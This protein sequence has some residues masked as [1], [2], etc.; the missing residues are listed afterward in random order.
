VFSLAQTSSIIIQQA[1]AATEVVQ[2]VGEHAEQAGHTASHASPHAV[3]WVTLLAKVVGDTSTIGHLL[4]QGEKIIFALIAIMLI[5]IFCFRVSSRISIIPTKLQVILESVVLMLDGLVCSSTGSAKGRI[6]TPF[7]GSLFIYIF[8]SNFYG[9]IPLQNSATAYI[10]TTA[11]LALSVFLYVQWIAWTKNGF[12]GYLDHLAGNP[13]DLM[14]YMLTPLFLP[15]HILGEITRPLT[16][17]FRLFGN[18]TAGHIMVGVFLVMGVNMLK[19]Y[20]VPMG[21][22]VHIPFLFLEVLVCLI[23]ALVFA[24]LTAVYIGSALPHDEEHAHHHDDLAAEQAHEES[25]QG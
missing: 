24:L 7:V 17:M 11:P 14:G 12:I 18:I 4:I 5:T 1:Q 21:M 25:T 22:P 10:T 15:I 2:Q 13:R 3:N 8:V 23:Q 16:L 19:P 6:Y 20:G 9:L